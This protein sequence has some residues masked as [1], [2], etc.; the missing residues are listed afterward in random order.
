M[1]VKILDMAFD[2]TQGDLST[3][4]SKSRKSG[5]TSLIIL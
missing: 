5:T 3:A 2:K 4:K 1:V